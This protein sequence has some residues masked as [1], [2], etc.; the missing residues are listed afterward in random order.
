MD[1][2]IK[3]MLTL[4]WVYLKKGKS[5]IAERVYKGEWLNREKVN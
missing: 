3:K 1:G 4:V 2:R 5:R